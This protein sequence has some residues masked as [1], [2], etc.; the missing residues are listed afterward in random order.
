V[1]VKPKTASVGT[2]G[3]FGGSAAT[4]V[5]MLQRR[6]LAG[7]VDEF[8]GISGVCWEHGND[9]SVVVLVVASAL[10]REGVTN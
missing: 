1:Y 6:R 8:H 7:I 3:F 10:Q 4:W 5:G 9:V 2:R